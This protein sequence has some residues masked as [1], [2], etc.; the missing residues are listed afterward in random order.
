MMAVWLIMM[1]KQM[2]AIFQANIRIEKNIG[3]TFFSLTST[4][5]VAN[6]DLPILVVSHPLDTLL[7]LIKEV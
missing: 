4:R 5:S 6:P 3:D 2:L 1:P 7:N